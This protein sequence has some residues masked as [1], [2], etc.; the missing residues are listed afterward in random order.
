MPSGP[1]VADPSLIIIGKVLAPHGVRGEVRVAVLTDFP[2]RFNTMKKVL[3]EDGRVLDVEFCRSHRQQF[4]IKFQGYDDRNNADGLRGK[5][6]QVKRDD[7]WQLPPGHY[8]VFDIIG[9]KVFDDAGV[10]LGV[11]KDVL[12]TGSNDVYIVEQA[13]KPPLLI[14][15][16]KDVVQKI[17][18]PGGQMIVKLQEEWN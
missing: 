13:D 2:E 10:L 9:L 1:K 3:L 12:A 18:V 4:L 8:Y 5:L 7:V 6:L 17:D 16:L 15:A 11:V 14:P